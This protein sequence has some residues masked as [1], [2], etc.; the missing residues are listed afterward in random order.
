M[1]NPNLAAAWFLGGY[2]RTWRGE[3]DEAIKR[4][5]HAMRLSPLDSE[6]FRMQT[7]IAM[8]HLIAKRFDTACGWAEKAYRDVPVFVVPAA[9][10]AASYALAGRMDEAQRAM[11]HVRRL[12]PALRLASLDKWLPFQTTARRR[13]LRRWTAKGGAAGMTVR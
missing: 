2:L 5:E 4:F 7:G 8:A 1:L 12:D 11:R 9:A 13:T 3:P 6:M 10:I